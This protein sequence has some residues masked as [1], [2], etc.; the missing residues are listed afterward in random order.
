MVWHFILFGTLDISI[1]F[2]DGNG[3]WL[4][5]D[6]SVILIVI[7]STD[8]L[9][10]VRFNSL[11]FTC[12]ITYSN[13]MII[14]FGLRWTRLLVNNSNTIWFILTW[15]YFFVKY[16][17]SFGFECLARLGWHGLL[18]W[19][20]TLFLDFCN[21][22]LNYWLLIDS[23]QNI[24]GHIA[25][26]MRKTHSLKIWNLCWIWSVD[27]GWLQ[28]RFAASDT[29]NISILEHSDLLVVPRPL[30]LGTFKGVGFH[31]LLFFFSLGLLLFN[32]KP[33]LLDTGQ[34][35]DDQ[36]YQTETCDEH[37]DHCCLILLI[38]PVPRRRARIRSIVCT[39]PRASGIGYFIIWGTPNWHLFRQGLLWVRVSPFFLF[40]T[41]IC[42]KWQRYI[43]CINACEMNCIEVFSFV[44]ALSIVIDPDLINFIVITKLVMPTL[45][46][47]PLCLT[48]CQL[49]RSILQLW[50][51]FELLVHWCMVPLVQKLLGHRALTSCYVH[52]LS[53]AANWEEL[54]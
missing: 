46:R 25:A 37:E 23:W 1:G 52:L 54:K 43:Q 11:G 19:V 15:S 4:V 38:C 8:K 22:T 24:G 30:P 20:V 48:K 51:G 49:P 7:W 27:L 45:I 36:D 13:A 26:S 9:V 6:F 34:N 17:E 29:Y 12:C 41:L 18:A 32:C 31:H 39:H 5:Q 50:S 47:G 14:C 21:L 40:L 35:C 2:Y 10:L 53:M 44:E 33:P 42:I 28:A 3:L 16:F